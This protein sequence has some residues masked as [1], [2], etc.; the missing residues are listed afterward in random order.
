MEQGNLW[1]GFVR[2]RRNLI[3]GSLALFFIQISGLDFKQLNILGTT[4]DIKNP[5]AIEL[6]IW[7]AVIY[8]LFRFHQYKNELGDVGTK[9]QY[10]KLLA[11]HLKPKAYKY[12][13]EHMEEYL[14]PNR[15]PEKIFIGSQ[16]L[17]VLL[18]T[19]GKVRLTASLMFRENGSNGD[20]TNQKFDFSL[21]QALIPK[22]NA[23]IDLC[24]NSHH[25]TEYYLPI[26][27]FM[28][29]L[30]GLAIRFFYN[31]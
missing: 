28:I 26:A 25:F 21:S 20:I 7:V 12:V 3:I 13:A 19:G 10:L 2:Q 4:A 11:K 15:I 31:L 24:F 23:F 16:Q 6:F 8:W 5:V 30:M 17:N 18:G 1:S 9:S 14:G 27:I 29:P 22:I